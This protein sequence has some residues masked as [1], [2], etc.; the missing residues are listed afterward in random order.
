MPKE[1]ALL[2]CSGFVLYLL[3]LES[4]QSVNVSRALWIPTL[5]MMIAASRP[6]ASW[7]GD[8]TADSGSVSNQIVL[9]GLMALGLFVLIRRGVDWPLIFRAN[10]WLW[11]LLFYMLASAAWSDIPGASLKRWIR[12]VQAPLMAL[13]VLTD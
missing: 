9:L 8:G 12:E 10:S 3:R 5:W 13:V 6:V 2:L 11:I 7:F 4:M 1:L